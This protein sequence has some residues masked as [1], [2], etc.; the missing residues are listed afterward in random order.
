MKSSWNWR[1]REFD[2]DGI[3]PDRGLTDRTIGRSMAEIAS[4]VV[5]G[6][7]AADPIGVEIRDGEGQRDEAASRPGNPIQEL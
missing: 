2:A 3:D 7:S 5:G 1:G 6:L 4:P